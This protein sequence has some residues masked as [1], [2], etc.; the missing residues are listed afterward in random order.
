MSNLNNHPRV[1]GILENYLGGSMN[2]CRPD[3]SSGQNSYLMT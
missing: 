3:E 1:A 2:E